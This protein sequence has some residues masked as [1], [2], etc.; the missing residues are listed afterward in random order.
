G[1]EMP[2]WRKKQKRRLVEAAKFYLFDIGVANYLNPEGHRVM[3]GSDS[4]GRAFEHFIINEIRAYLSYRQLDAPLCYWRT[5]SG[6][7]VD[8][9]VGDM[10]IAIEIKS[11]REIRNSDLKGLRAL[12]EEHKVGKSFVVSRDKQR[13]KTADGTEMIHWSEFCRRLWQSDFVK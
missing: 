9:I 4:Y 7:E 2:A 6:F 13:R 10:D 1:F 5:S 8:L 3:P 11:T 12:A